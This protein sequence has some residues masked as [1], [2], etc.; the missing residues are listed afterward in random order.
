MTGEVETDGEGVRATVALYDA[1]RGRLVEERTY[2]GTGVFE[3]ADE[4]SARLR[5]DLN[6]PELDVGG[7]QDLPAAEMLTHEP[8]AFRLYIE[9]RRKIWVD[10]DFAGGVPLLQAAVEVDP[11]YADA[12]YTLGRYA[13]LTG[14]GILGS[15]PLQAAMDHLYRLPERARFP[16]KSDYYLLVREDADK[17]LSVLEMWAELFPDDIMAYEK[18]EISHMGRGDWEG[19]VAD[20]GKILEL[21][22]GRGEV[23]LRL[24]SA[25][26]R[27]G[28]EA[29]A[30]VVVQRYADQFPADHGGLEQLASLARRAGDL[31]EA[32]RLQERALLLEP[33]NAALMREMGS[34][35]RRLGNFEQALEQYEAALASAG[36]GQERWF[37]L[38]ALEA[39]YAQRG[40]MARAIGYVEERLAEAPTYRPA[41]FVALA[42]LSAVNRYV[43]AG[44]IDDARALIE[45]ARAEMP[46]ASRSMVSLGELWLRLALEDADGID[47]AIP[48]VE[49]MIETLGQEGYRSYVVHAR[50]RVHELRGEFRQAIEWYEEEQR[51]APS[52]LS[53]S[54]YLG[55]CHRGLEQYDRAVSLFQESLR[56]SPYA[57]LT[58]YE[59]AITYR[60]MGR[61][62]DARSHLERALDVWA[63]AD[64]G[65]EPARRARE[66]LA[67]LAG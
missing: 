37:A 41:L 47:A 36:T 46:P 17:A 29:S 10:Q 12:Q 21:D 22:A 66:A 39:H 43:G 11:T 40:Q 33:S 38:S 60:A 28:D 44:R 58:N 3:L 59:L 20:L 65:Y 9:A 61:T 54:T 50:A 55:R 18:L 6:V 15:A 42:R 23:L 63:E 48:G 34:A 26:I 45:G 4:I 31:E 56:S 24:G 53:I 62:D 16:V 1:Q 64:P 35:E 19:V 67:A 7:P 2:S 49:A 51:L 13:R 27:K 52:D 5:E 14:Q 57:P 30:R 25:Y 32:R 8:E